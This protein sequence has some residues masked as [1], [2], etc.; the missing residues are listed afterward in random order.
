VG[1]VDRLPGNRNNQIE[2]NILELT[3]CFTVPLCRCI[4]VHGTDNVLVERNVCYDHVGHGFMLEDGC[5]E[6]NKF[7]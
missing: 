1:C 2:I 6:G 7:S 4:V 5:E 3:T